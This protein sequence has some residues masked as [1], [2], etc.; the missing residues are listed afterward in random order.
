VNLIPV[1]PIE[2]RDYKRS[3]KESVEAFAKLLEKNHIN[4]TVR[5]EMGADIQAACGQLRKRYN[6]KKGE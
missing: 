4:A 2:E 3:A 5:R 6:D 1:N